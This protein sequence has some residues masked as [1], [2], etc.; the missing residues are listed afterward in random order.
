MSLAT[1]SGPDL[2]RLK[3]RSRRGM[4][5]NDLV[6]QTFYE[7]HEAALDPETVS[8]LNALLDLPDGELWDLVTGRLELEEG[9]PNIALAQPVLTLLRACEAAKQVS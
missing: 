3:W 8:G 6:L 5:E 1:L 4:L 9:A 2:A 7:R